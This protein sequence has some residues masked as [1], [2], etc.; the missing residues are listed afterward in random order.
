[1]GNANNCLQKVKSSTKNLT[2]SR[3]SLVVETVHRSSHVCV[4]VC[5]CV[6]TC[7]FSYSSG[8]PKRSD[9]FVFKCLPHLSRFGSLFFEISTKNLFLKRDFAC[10]LN[11]PCAVALA[12][13]AQRL[14]GKGNFF[15]GSS[16]Y[17]TQRWY[18]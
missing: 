2:N 10:F 13:S 9:R 12:L 16:F 8:R 5:V 7:I 17:A 15:L 18:E 11:V 6:W 3:I 1:M 14:Q 4:C